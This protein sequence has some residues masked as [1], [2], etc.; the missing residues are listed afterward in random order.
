MTSSSYSKKR[1]FFTID[2][3]SIGT[4]MLSKGIREHGEW[5]CIKLQT[6]LQSLRERTPLLFAIS[7]LWSL[8]EFSLFF[9]L[10]RFKLF[11]ENENLELSLGWGICAQ[12]QSPSVEWLGFFYLLCSSLFLLNPFQTNFPVYHKTLYRKTK[13]LLKTSFVTGTKYLTILHETVYNGVQDRLSL[14][15]TLPTPNL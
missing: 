3:T 7:A 6:Q 14:F 15:I 10:L 12:C 2:I 1:S 13:N 5:F 8:T 11:Q 9:S 4:P